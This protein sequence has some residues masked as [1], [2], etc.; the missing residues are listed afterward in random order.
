MAEK[1]AF[2]ALKQQNAREEVE[3]KSGILDIIMQAWR[4][5]ALFSHFCL[6]K[7]EQNAKIYF[8]HAFWWSCPHDSFTKVRVL[9]AASPR[10][11]RRM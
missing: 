3:S 2:C 1:E 6:R 9:S 8:L 5:L 11:S 10:L 7:I 4:W